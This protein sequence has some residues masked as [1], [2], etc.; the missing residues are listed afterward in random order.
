MRSVGDIAFNPPLRKSKRKSSQFVLLYRI[1][2]CCKL[3]FSMYT[4][5]ILKNINLHSVIGHDYTHILN[6]QSRTWLRDDHS[7]Y[8]V[9]VARSRGAATNCIQSS[10]NRHCLTTAV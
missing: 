10:D 4:F 8:P 6:G 7:L 1:I 9:E 5:I 2:S 3:F